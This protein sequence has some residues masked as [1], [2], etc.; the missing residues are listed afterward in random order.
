M[1][2][3]LDEDLYTPKETKAEAPIFS[4]IAL[5]ILWAGMISTFSEGLGDRTKVI[6]AVCCLSF[7]TIAT[8]VHRGFG[9]K[10]TMLVLVLAMFRFLVFLPASYYVSFGIEYYQLGFDVLIFGFGLM[11][12]IAN[13]SVLSQF[14]EDSGKTRLS[15]KEMRQRQ[16]AKVETFKQR[17]TRKSV[18]ELRLKTLNDELVPEAIL[19]AEQLILEK[20][21]V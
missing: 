4:W 8:L 1:R 18:E 14:F 9:V 7:A 16:I 20:E 13:R 11:H 15:E 2:E 19:A 12:Y 3:L 17:F 21:L 6:A 5:F 10:A